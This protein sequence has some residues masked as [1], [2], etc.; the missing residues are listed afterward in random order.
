MYKRI[1]TIVIDSVGCGEAPKSYLYGDKNVNTVCL[2]I[3]IC[4]NFDI[5]HIIFVRLLNELHEITGHR[6]KR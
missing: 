5:L 1:F 2:K 4:V 6:S 3:R